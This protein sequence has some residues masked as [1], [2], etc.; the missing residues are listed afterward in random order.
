MSQDREKNT[1]TNRVARWKKVV[2]VGLGLALGALAGIV[3]GS[4]AGIGIAMI[5]GIL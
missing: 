3:A 2:S 1:P 4:V 5:L